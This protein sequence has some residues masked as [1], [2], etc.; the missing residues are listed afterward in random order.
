MAR[1]YVGNLPYTTND[2]DLAQAFSQFGTVVSSAVIKDKATRRSKGF[3]F[4][5][6]ESE[7]KAQE[8]ISGMDGKDFEGRTL[9]VSMAKPMEQR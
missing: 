1:I 3:G 7:E 4:V 8:A 6:F 2:Q 9:K 5:E